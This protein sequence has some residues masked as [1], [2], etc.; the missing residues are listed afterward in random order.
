MKAGIGIGTNVSRRSVVG[1]N[2]I[3]QRELGLK[4]LNLT[5]LIM[6]IVW[7]Q[8]VGK[9]RWSEFDLAIEPIDYDEQDRLEAELNELRVTCS[10]C[11]H[12]VEPHPRKMGDE[13]GIFWIYECPNCYWDI[14]DE[15]EL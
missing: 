5:M 9:I 6:K 1:A 15:V 13:N 12:L 7:R 4:L 10:S 3:T 8:D 11:R 2:G 14:T